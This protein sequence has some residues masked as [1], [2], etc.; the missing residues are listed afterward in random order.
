M[1]VFIDTS[2]FLWA[3]NYPD[4][5]SA[6][7]VRMANDGKIEGIT[8]ENVLAELKS[9]Y[10][11]YHDARTWFEVEALITAK[12]K[13]VWRKEIEFE[14]N[15]LTSLINRKDLEQI[16]SAKYLKIPLV[17][18]DRDFENFPEYITPKQFV[19]KL[20]LKTSE[21]DYYSNTLKFSDNYYAYCN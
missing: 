2:T 10:T 12:Y 14:T 20:G 21:T 11:T 1:R 9:Y 16:A 8:G 18:F 19:K 6:K 15:N 4:S 7:I 13:I 5:N 17:A 3:Y